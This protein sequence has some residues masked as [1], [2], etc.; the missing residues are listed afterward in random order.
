MFSPWLQALLQEAHDV[1]VKKEKAEVKIE[2]QLAFNKE[3]TATEVA[4]IRV[5]LLKWVVPK[6]TE[7]VPVF[8]RRRSLKSK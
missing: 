1:E 8:F 5:L 2:R 4:F 6:L 3:D 7:H